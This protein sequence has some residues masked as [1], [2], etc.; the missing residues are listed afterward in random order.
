[1]VDQ[2]QKA[3]YMTMAWFITNGFLFLE[4]CEGYVLEWK[5]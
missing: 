2:K 1:M 5:S 3:D 4:M